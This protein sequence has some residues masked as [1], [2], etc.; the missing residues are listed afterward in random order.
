MIR[1]YFLIAVRNIIRDKVFSTINIVGLAV[2]ITCFLALFLFVQDELTFDQVDSA[3]DSGQV[4]RVYSRMVMNGSEDNAKTAQV[5]GPILQQNYP[6]VKSFAT[7]GYFGPR[8]FKY[9]DK[10]LVV[11]RVPWLNLT[12]LYLQKQLQKEYSETKVP[13]ANCCRRN[14]DKL[15]KSRL[16]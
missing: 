12:Q 8:A 14:Q 10:V 2:G 16:V 15:S 4:Y 13:W 3:F 9:N 1:N 6:E 11:L 5:P 7:I